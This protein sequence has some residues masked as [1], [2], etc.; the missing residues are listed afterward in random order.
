MLRG[1][2]DLTSNAPSLNHDSLGNNIS[3]DQYDVLKKQTGCSLGHFVL[4]PYAWVIIVL[5]KHMPQYYS[6]LKYSP[7]FY[8][9][10][11]QEG[12]EQFP[13]ALQSLAPRK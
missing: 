12:D 3:Q 13:P 9:I 6:L 2:K 11:L 8:F 4:H 10:A 7:I 5:E 1:I